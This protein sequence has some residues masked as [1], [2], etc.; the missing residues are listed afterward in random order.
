M[1]R[2]R[3]RRVLRPEADRAAADLP[4]SAVVRPGPPVK[5]SLMVK[6][7]VSAKDA[8]AHHVFGAF[9]RLTPEQ[10]DEFLHLCLDDER[11]NAIRAFS[12]DYFEAQT[13]SAELA[14]IK[15]GRTANLEL[16][17][18]VVRL[19]DEE[20]LSFGQIGIQ[21]RPRKEYDAVRK[22]YKRTKTRIARE[23]KADALRFGIN[24]KSS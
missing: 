8:S 13:H 18:R 7:K 16:G 23:Q 14:R 22:I 11:P 15:A 1:G 24:G 21:L 6:R 10:Q 3:H 2:L 9:K 12:W 5:G 20:G 4:F 19:H 17:M